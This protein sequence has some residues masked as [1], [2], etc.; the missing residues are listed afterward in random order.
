MMGK[1]NISYKAQ[2]GCKKLG[3]FFEEK[4]EEEK[5]DN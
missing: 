2:E 1:S 5:K 4:T 3:T